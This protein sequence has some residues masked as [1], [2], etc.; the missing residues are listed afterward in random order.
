MPVSPALPAD[1]P[2]QL[3]A[4]RRGLGSLKVR[5]LDAD[6]RPARGTVEIL[7]SFNQPEY[8]ASS[9]EN[10]IVVFRDLSSGRYRLQ[11][12]PRRPAA[13]R[14]GFHGVEPAAGGLRACG[15]TR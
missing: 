6:G 4:V 12:I 3:L 5:L 8:A 1:L 15:G 14:A 2:I 13:A 7:E 10:G 9:D 11:R